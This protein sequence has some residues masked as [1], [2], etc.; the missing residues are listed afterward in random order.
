MADSLGFHLIQ[1]GTCV[2]TGHMHHQI[3]GII[4]RRSAFGRIGLGVMPGRDR[5][6]WR[7]GWREALGERPD[8]VFERQYDVR[9]AHL[10][11]LGEQSGAMQYMTQLANIPRP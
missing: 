2:H 6:G 10:C 11:A 1:G 4:Q 7:R 5:R 9:R 3:G 8:T